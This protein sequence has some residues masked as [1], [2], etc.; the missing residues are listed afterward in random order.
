MVSKTATEELY[1]GSPEA[2]RSKEVPGKRAAETGKSCLMSGTH[3]LGLSFLLFSSSLPSSYMNRG[4]SHLMTTFCGFMMV[5]SKGYL[6][7]KNKL[8]WI[9]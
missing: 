7:D 8:L 9:L 1:T 5:T 2:V 4:H 6:R 3:L